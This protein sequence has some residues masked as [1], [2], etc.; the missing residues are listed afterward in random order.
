LITFLKQAGVQF[1][2]VQFAGVQFA[3]V[4]R[5]QKGVASFLINPKKNIDDSVM[6]HILVPVDFSDLSLVA[7]QA[8]NTMASLFGGYVS[9]VHAHIP[10]TEL[11]EPYALGV[12]TNVYQNFEEIQASL[13]S[14]LRELSKQY[15][16]EAVRGEVKVVAGNPAQ[17][18]MYEAEHADFIVMSTHGRTGFRRFLL[19]S[20]AEKIVRMSPVP[21]L[22]VEPESDLGGLEHIVVTT[23][24]SENSEFA[25]PIALDIAQKSGGDVTLLHVLNFEQIEGETMDRSLQEIRRQRIDLLGK[26]HFKDLGD[27][28]HT[29][30]ILFDGSA[31]KAIYEY[32]QKHNFQLLVMSTA[33]RTGLN[34]MMMGST[35]ANVVRLTDTAVLSVRPPKP[36]ESS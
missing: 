27:R 17:C 13:E 11:D 22:I 33:G 18:V 5:E 12:S 30:V 14:R 23:D 16:D 24:F 7:I 19:G 28:L 20:I 26:E 31:N 34:Y 1:A 15:L 9:L 6:K 21:V 10:I 32:L 29:D 35:T 36:S 4:S 25:F 8:A 3:G 2:G